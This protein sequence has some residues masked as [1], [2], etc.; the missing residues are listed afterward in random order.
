MDINKAGQVSYIRNRIDHL[1]RQGEENARIL[2]QLRTEL[3][4]LEESSFVCVQFAGHAKEYCY[5]VEEPCRVGE[6]CVVWSP[7]TNREE[8]VK[9]T[10]LG[11]GHWTGSHSKIAK[12]VVYAT[13]GDAVHHNF[14]SDIHDRDQVSF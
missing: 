8:I 10:R 11:R 1:E 7:Q 3:R 5:E 9:I 13:T 2:R 14:R 4:Q 6:Y 12:R